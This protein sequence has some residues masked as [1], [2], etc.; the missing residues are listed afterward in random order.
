MD[1]FG[2]LVGFL[3]GLGVSGFALIV[4]S[5]AS[6]DCGFGGELVV[7]TVGCLSCVRR[8]VEYPATGPLNVGVRVT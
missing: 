8:T 1:D 4:V 2:D 7:L 5:G 6:V 3:V